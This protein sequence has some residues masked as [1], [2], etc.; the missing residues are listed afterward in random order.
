MNLGIP[1]FNCQIYVSYSLRALGE[2]LPNRPIG[3][4]FRVFVP[5]GSAAEQK[6]EKGVGRVRKMIY[7]G[8]HK[9]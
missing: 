4:V 2:Y 1:Q 3:A 5:F 9:S 8:R 6:H 7:L